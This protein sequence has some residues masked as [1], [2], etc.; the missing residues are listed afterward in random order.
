[1]KFTLDTKFRD[2]GAPIAT[3]AF[4]QELIGKSMAELETGRLW[5]Q[6]QLAL[7]TAEPALLPKSEVV[8]QWRIAKGEVSEASFRVAQLALKMCGTSNTGNSS[9]ISRMLRDIAMSLVM[10]FPAERGRLEAAKALVEGQE[11]VTF[12]V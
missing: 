3:S 6:K 12:T 4:H 9:V 1:M 10:A 7:E 2:S 5:L 8:W 11:T